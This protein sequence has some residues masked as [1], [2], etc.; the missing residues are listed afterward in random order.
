MGT[1]KA[2]VA[3]ASKAKRLARVGELSVT[4]LRRGG[5]RTMKIEIMR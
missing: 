5:T 2:S 4:T 1:T 3:I